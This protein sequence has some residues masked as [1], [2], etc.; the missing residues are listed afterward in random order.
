MT[1]AN[2]SACCVVSSPRGSGRARV[3]AILASIFCSTRQL[4]TAAAAA[5]RAMPSVPNSIGFNGGKPGTARNMPITAV[6]T[7]S[8]TTRGLVSERNWRRRCWSRASAVIGSL[9]Q[10]VWARE[11]ILPFRPSA[12]PRRS[13]QTFEILGHPLDVGIRRIA[14]HDV[15]QRIDQ[16][17]VRRRTGVA[18][19]SFPL[20]RIDACDDQPRVL[21]QKLRRE[22]GRLGRPQPD[23]HHALLF[24]PLDR[25]R[26]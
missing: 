12:D 17:D 20:C 14:K 8:D 16:I 13:Q 6:N 25:A 2:I 11:G 10:T 26:L 22:R 19:Q 1:D 24:A 3:R 4:I 5:T 9:A 7:I 15:A 23:A 18:W 21:R